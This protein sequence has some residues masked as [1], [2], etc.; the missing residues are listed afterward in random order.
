MAIVALITIMFTPSIIIQQ[1]L[2]S[3]IQGR[4]NGIFLD[5]SLAS[6]VQGSGNAVISHA[7]HVHAI[8]SQLQGSDNAASQVQGKGNAAGPG[9]TPTTVV[10]H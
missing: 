5:R 3:Q 8:S 4:G 6:Q 2:A 10:H 1:S 7:T 9:S